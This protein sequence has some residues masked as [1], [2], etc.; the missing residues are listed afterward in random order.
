MF[1]SYIQTQVYIL[2]L[3]STLDTPVTGVLEQYITAENF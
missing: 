2:E 1:R 3:E